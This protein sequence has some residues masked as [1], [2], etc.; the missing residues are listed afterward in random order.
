M[1]NKN[2]ILLFRLIDPIIEN[3]IAEEA[4]KTY[5]DSQMVNNRNISVSNAKPTG[6]LITR[7][8][9]ATDATENSE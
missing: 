8:R 7:S 3:L 4:L 6:S 2:P 5:G 9:E 1:E